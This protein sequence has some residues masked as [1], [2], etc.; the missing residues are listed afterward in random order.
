MIEWPLVLFTVSLQLACGLALSVTLIEFMDGPSFVA[1]P[2][3]IAVFPVAM[4]GEVASLFHL[5]HPF[6]A[7]RA[8]RNLASSPLSREVVAIVLFLVASLAYSYLWWRDKRAVRPVVGVTTSALGLVAVV[9]SSMIYLVPSRPVWNSGWVPAS[10]FG[11]TL[12]LAGFSSVTFADLKD[13][14]RLLW[15]N[16]AAAVS[17]SVMVFGSAIWM[18]ANLSKVSADDYAAKQLQQAR[19]LLEGSQYLGWFALYVLLT[20]VVPVA[21]ASRYWPGHGDRGESKSP[22]RFAGFLAIVLGV[23]IGRAIMYALGVS[24]PSF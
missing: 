7:Y 9:F 10:F 24:I 22:G 15:S 14:S 6:L 11:S 3:A 19:S 18:L 1:R 8:I 12:L 17:G 23:V 2:M 20:V 13:H 21:L 4:F 5:G 16:L